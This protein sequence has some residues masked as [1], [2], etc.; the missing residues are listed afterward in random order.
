MPMQ[1]SLA[2]LIE[3][4]DMLFSLLLFCV[5]FFVFFAGFG[6]LHYICTN[7]NPKLKMT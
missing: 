1:P 7:T 4:K 2:L 3:L 5:K 6:K